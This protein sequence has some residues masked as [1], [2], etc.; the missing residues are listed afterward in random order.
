MK[1][2]RFIKELENAGWQATG[3]AQHENIKCLH[4]R[5]FPV[6][7]ELEADVITLEQYIDRSIEHSRG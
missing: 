1:L 5:L 6:I 2:N 3:D 4:A 7:A